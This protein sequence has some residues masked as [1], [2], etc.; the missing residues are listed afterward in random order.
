MH[1]LQG[2]IEGEERPGDLR[3]ATR[4]LEGRFSTG[5][6]GKFHYPRAVRTPRQLRH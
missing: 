6:E 5:R 2:S 4:R 3:T 1:E